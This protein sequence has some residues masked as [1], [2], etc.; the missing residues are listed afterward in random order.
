MSE[1]LL[2][3]DFLTVDL[4]TMLKSR[5]TDETALN[6]NQHSS[7]ATSEIQK[8][9]VNYNWRQD[10]QDRLDANKRMSPESRLSKYSIE[11]QF[12]T[13]FYNHLFKNNATLVKRALQIGSLLQKDLKIRDFT[14]SKNPIVAFLKI[15][16]VQNA[17][18]STGLLNAN[19]YKA[20]HN[21]V[22]KSMMAE[23]EF[24]KR[25]R[26]NIIYCRN[27]Y[28]KTAVEMEKYLELQGSI[29]S[30]SKYPY[31]AKTQEANIKV[32]FYINGIK[33]QNAVRRKKEIDTYSGEL[34]SAIQ[35]STTL[36]D[37]EL[38]KTL[39]NTYGYSSYENNKKV[40]S[41][42]VLTKQLNKLE[43]FF[44]VLQYLSI[45][46]KSDAAKKA[47]KHQKFNELRAEQIAQA[48]EAI[49]PILRKV[50]MSEED[51][52]ALVSSIVQKLNEL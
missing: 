9:P 44:A 1:R 49:A 40:T 26:Y 34:P 39:C 10:L 4:S 48:T 42:P 37:I 46:T 30:A 17:L 18:L 50:S 24:Y 21:A 29:L 5:Y 6:S 16:Y 13:D 51:V 43:Q 41:V 11:T 25:N 45:T 47:M 15:T 8:K 52:T 22:A 7:E 35:A 12:F 32:F 20:I 36:N 3:S 2:E 38:C 14:A 28:T 23:R 19:T 27:L 31:T 33:E